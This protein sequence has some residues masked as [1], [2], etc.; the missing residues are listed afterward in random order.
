MPAKI[1]SKVAAAAFR[2]AGLKPLEPYKGNIKP[3]KARHI[4]CG[5]VVNPSFNAIKRGQG[6]C[7][8]C[9]GKAIYPPDAV[10]LFLK[11]GLKPIEPYPGNN[12]KPW[13][14]VHIP[15]G[16][17]VSP[18]YAIV[19]RGESIGC[20][21]CSDQFV[22]PD[23]AF[24]FFLSR[25]L[26][27]L[28]PYPGANKPWKSI[29][30]I[31]GQVIG[32]RYGHI[33]AGR[34]GCPVCA[35]TVPITQKRALEFWR[36]NELEPLETFKGPHHP[37]KS[38]H[39]VCGRKISPRWSNVTSG[40]NVCVYCSNKRVDAKDVKRLLKEHQL[41]LLKPFETSDKP[42]SAIHLKCG[43]R[44]SP[45]FAALRSGQ[46]PCEFC[47]KNM[48]S[49]EEALELLTR[50]GFTPLVDFPG[51]SKLWK[52][53]HNPCGQEVK[54]R[55]TY[56]RGGGKGCNFCSGLLPISSV[57]ATKLFKARGFTPLV[58]FSGS[59]KPW[60][61][62]HNVCGRIVYPSYQSVKSG[63]GCKYCQIGGINL[64]APA[65]IY[66]ITNKEMNSHK[67]G[68]GGFGTSSNRLER[69]L[70]LGWLSYRRLSFET[71]EQAYEIEQAVLN[72]IRDD[73][74][75]KPYLL[76][77]Q[78]PQGGHTETVDASEI[79]LP[80]I[81]EKIRHLSRAKK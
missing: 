31:C 24:Q 52:C 14:C 66:L 80:V 25:N 59:K 76:P 8:Y 34:R 46:G 63:S 81:W 68:I 69:H 28:V 51:G 60:K 72:W 16:K 42:L 53:I 37:W 11:K 49:K 29:H 75:L 15:C 73:L 13:K 12:K 18:K 54:V 2:R 67:V 55:V 70:S 41:R 26:Q 33:K 65:Y 44:V 3:W 5:R 50:R 7:K 36:E 21:N 9:A 62:R 10:K 56:L 61:S 58:K 39:I 77:K 40:S 23:E 47:S 71:A 27:P 17:E 45:R 4:K 1:D 35:G 19:A 20:R 57:K 79:D 78:M 38:R 74:G 43:R 30:L 22:D 48:V 64:L 6:A 32:P